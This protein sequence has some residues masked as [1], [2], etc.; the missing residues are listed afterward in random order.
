MERFIGID[1]GAETI[2]LAELGG[3][4]DG[5]RLVRH[6]VVPHGKEPGAR[7]I[8]VL[9]AWDWRT[10]T[11]VAAT[12]RLGRPARGRPDPHAER[13]PAR[14]QVPLRERPGDDR[15]DRQPGHLRPRDSGGRR[16]GLPR[17]VP[18]RAGDRQL[19]APARRPVLPDRRGGGARRRGGRR[20][21]PA[22]GPLPG[23]PQDGHDAPREQGRAAGPDPRRPPRR[24]RGERRGPREAA[25][26]PAARAPDRRR[27]PVAPRA[28]ALP[29][30]PRP[31]RHGAPRAAKAASSSSSR[32]WAARSTPPRCARAPAPWRTSSATSRRRDRERA[33]AR[34]ARSPGSGG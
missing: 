21:R 29:D 9:Q 19:P 11:S 10:V 4:D 30:V 6:A 13:A 34:R 20:A 5:L 31:Q 7:L 25:A 24:H 27:D 8:E 1:V 12:G 16:V 2:K 23:H 32:R 33:A 15:L 22:L 26:L 3:Y 28:R 18:L 17:V 14:V